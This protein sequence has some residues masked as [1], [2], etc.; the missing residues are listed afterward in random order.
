MDFSKP[1]GKL[2]KIISIILFT[3]FIFLVNA[4]EG[5]KTIGLQFK[6]I[7][8]SNLLKAGTFGLSSNKDFMEYSITQNLGYS[9]GMIIRF[10]LTKNWSIESSIK[11]TKR[12]FSYSATNNREQITLKDKF[13]IIGY[14]VPVLALLTVRLDKKIYMNTTFG[15]S[16]DMY[17]TDVAKYSQAF[18]QLSLRRRWLQLSLKAN[19]GWEYRTDKN[20]IFYIGASFHRPFNDIYQTT[21]TYEG[22]DFSDEAIERLS[23]N[24]LTLDLRYFFHEDPEKKSK[25]TRHY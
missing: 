16:F 15:P 21:I 11:Y 22:I 9:A 3:S 23:G 18:R 25:R 17:P 20:G 1:N 14:E 13:S 5:V 7:I 24:Y 10:G 8:P 6:P 4:Q 2:K 12:N 19:I